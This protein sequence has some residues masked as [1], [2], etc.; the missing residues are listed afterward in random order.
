MNVRRLIIWFCALGIFSS[1]A[2]TALPQDVVPCKAVRGGTKYKRAEIG[3]SYGKPDH[4]S[5]NILV[6]PKNINADFLYNLSRTIRS[7]YCTAVHISVAIY[8]DAKLMDYGWE[9]Y[10]K[11]S[12]EAPRMRAVYTLDMTN[13]IEQLQFS[14][15][16]RGNLD[17]NVIFLVAKDPR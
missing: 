7:K 3:P 13:G 16:P 10:N 4:I 6:K 17:G 9:I 11:T 15:S 14:T 8:D 2:V 12:D 5:G 1:A